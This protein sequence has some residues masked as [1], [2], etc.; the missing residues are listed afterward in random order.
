MMHA[1][2]GGTAPGLHV[3]S[4]P[5]ERLGAMSRQAALLEREGC[6]EEAACYWLAALA[7]A[8][9]GRD[10][11]WCESRAQLCQKRSM[12]VQDMWTF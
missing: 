4:T 2:I 6:F 1:D 8:V 9:S 12:Q 5:R 7:L 10:R 11:H 3:M